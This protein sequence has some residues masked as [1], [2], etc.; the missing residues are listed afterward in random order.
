MAVTWNPFTDNLDFTGTGSSGSATIPQYNSDPG[1][2][3]VNSAWV[4]KV[5][6][7]QL[8]TSLFPLGILLA[9]QVNA[10]KLS[11]RTSEGTTKRVLLT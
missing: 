5:P 7:Y 4:L 11:Y 10:Y 6:Q 3:A 8:Q 1:S 2:P 9:T